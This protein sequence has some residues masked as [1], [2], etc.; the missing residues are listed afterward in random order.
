MFLHRFW[1]PAAHP[2]FYSCRSASVKGPGRSRTPEEFGFSR[3]GLRL[4]SSPRSTFLLL[5][6]FFYAVDFDAAAGRRRFLSQAIKFN[7]M[8]PGLVLEPPVQRLEFFFVFA[9]LSWWCLRHVQ[10]VFGEISVRSFVGLFLTNRS[11]RS[12]FA[13]IWL[14]FRFDLRVLTQFRGLIAFL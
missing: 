9:V 2:S 5:S 6:P 7:F 12:Y 11:F 14:C 8:L 10:K 1:S 3:S 4:P 13:C